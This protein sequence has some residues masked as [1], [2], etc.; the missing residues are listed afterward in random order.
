MY[1]IAICE[2]DAQAAMANRALT[3]RLLD[4]RGMRNGQDYEIEV[5]DHLGSLTQRFEQDKA[6]FQLL[7]LDIVLGEENAIEWGYDLRRREVEVS[8]IYITDYPRFALDG[9]HTYPLEYLL[10]PV[11]E[12]LLDGALARDLKQHFPQERPILKTLSG[13]IL[14]EEVYYMEIEGRKTAVHTRD[15][16]RYLSESLSKIKAPF[17][18]QGF[19]HSHFSY[20]VNLAHVKRVDHGE[21]LLD[22]GATVPVSRRYYA[23]FMDSYIDYLK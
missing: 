18:A 20:L 3:A 11:D 7:M 14:L 22:N 10:K 21:L 16:C 5:F 19:C 1:R 2:D 15:D 17:L 9:Y 23:R 12:G 13:P 4:A 6:A 8:I